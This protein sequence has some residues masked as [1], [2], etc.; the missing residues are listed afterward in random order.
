MIKS[1][2]IAG[3]G[4]QGILVA[5]D[6]IAIAAMESGYDVKKSEIHGMSQRGGSVLSAVRYGEK[7]YSPVITIA[8][9]DVLLAFEKLEALR[10]LHYLKD[11]GLL[12]INDLEIDPLP[13]ASGNMKY[14]DNILEIILE[15]LHEKNIHILDANKIAVEAGNLRTMNVALLGSISHKLPEIT[16]EAWEKAI[17]QR[18]PAKAIDVNLKA[19]SMGKKE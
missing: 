7:V 19:F 13:V 2:Q 9:A 16:Q 14:P 11:G 12:V 3:V 15:K 18:V 8:Q 5:A 6:I 4:G 10:Q 1:I 17:K